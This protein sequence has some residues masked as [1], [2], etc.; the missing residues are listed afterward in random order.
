MQQ[1]EIIW[2]KIPNYDR[3]EASSS[4][5]IKTYNWKGSNKEAIMKPAKDSNGYF[6]TMLKRNDGKIHTVKVHRIIAQTFLENPENKKT[7]NHKN[8]VRDDNRVCN[9]EWNT[10]QENIDHAWKFLVKNP[11][12]G[13][14]IGTSTITDE[15]AQEILNNY[16]FGKRAKNGVNTKKQIAE[17]YG[18]SISVIKAI[19]MRV[20]FG[21]LTPNNESYYKS[22]IKPKTYKAKYR[23][24]KKEARI[25][26]LETELNKEKQLNKF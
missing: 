9:L 8:G 17:K 1:E 20:T 7:V 15:K 16:Q 6:R 3:Y 12:K 2:K 22:G 19:V 18:V 10:M 4:G 24:Q 13:D 26:E 5:H 11:L 14:K 23:K 25:K 21:H